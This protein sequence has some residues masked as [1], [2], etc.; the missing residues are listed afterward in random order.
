MAGARDQANETLWSRHGASVQG[1]A[2]GRVKGGFRMAED[3][4]VCRPHRGPRL[5]AMPQ[6]RTAGDRITEVIGRQLA[7]R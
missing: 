7:V 5:F 6:I 1:K 4:S 2:S 3:R